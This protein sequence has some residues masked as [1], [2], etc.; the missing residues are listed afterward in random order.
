MN[1]D[2]KYLAYLGLS[3]TSIMGAALF[4]LVG[5]NPKQEEYQLMPWIYSAICVATA[6]V[7][8]WAA[9]RNLQPLQLGAI[10][11]VNSNPSQDG[12]Q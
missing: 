10:S 9:R 4:V 5:V 8:G 2:A 12:R 7:T 6:F 1:N 11:A 3:L